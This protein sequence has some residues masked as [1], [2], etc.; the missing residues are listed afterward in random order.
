MEEELKYSFQ[1][2]FLQIGQYDRY[3]IFDFKYGSEAFLKY[4]STV[5]GFIIYTPSQRAALKIQTSS[6]AIPYED[7][8]IILDGALRDQKINKIL[9]SDGFYVHDIKR[10]STMDIGPFTNQY[11]NTHIKAIPNTI[12]IDF[13]P[14]LLDGERMQ[15][16]NFINR[17]KEGIPLISEE[18]RQYY[19]LMLLLDRERI[20]EEEK[21]QYLVN[22]KTG[23]FYDDVVLTLF[24]T[25]ASVD[26]EDGTSRKLVNRA[27]RNRRKE[28]TK[29]I[30]RHLGIAEKH[31]DNLKIENK[32]A[33]KELMKLIYGF[34]PETLTLWG[35]RHHIYWDFERFIHIYL[36]HYKSFLINESSKGQGTGFL[37]T[38]KDIRRII[39]IVIEQNQQSIEERLDQGKG[40]HIQNDNGYYYNGN[41]YSFKIDSD[42]KLMQFHPQENT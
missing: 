28:R 4:G 18:K 8:V 23:Y 27:L 11:D 5:Y 19:A 14:D 20:T 36:R 39:N 34:E 9:R 38:I 16:M 32:P 13:S 40:F 1:T 31:I 29:F 22:P 7:G 26:D 2:I 6:E 42:G 24:K 33:W 37:Y 15:Y 10:L 35:W 30:C 3:A 12:T 25:Y 21:Q 17:I 41:Y